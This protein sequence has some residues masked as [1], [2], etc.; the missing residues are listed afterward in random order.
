[1]PSSVEEHV[2]DAVVEALGPAEEQQHDSGPREEQTARGNLEQGRQGECLHRDGEARGD[3]IPSAH[4]V[5]E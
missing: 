5:E 3:G 4:I 2:G 1:M